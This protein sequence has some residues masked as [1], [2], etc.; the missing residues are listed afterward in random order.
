[1]REE[2]EEVSLSS[3]VQERS[4]L[5]GVN[6]KWAHDSEFAINK[7]KMAKNIFVFRK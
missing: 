4:A 7:S 5:G 1:M 2:E 6:D 3:D